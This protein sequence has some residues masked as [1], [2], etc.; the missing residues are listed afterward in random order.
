MHVVCLLTTFPC[1]AFLRTLCNFHF[2]LLL[3]S[4]NTERGANLMYFITFSKNNVFNHISDCP[5]AEFIEFSIGS[6]IVIHN[7]RF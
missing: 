5:V 3:L 1:V 7:T 6:R 2:F 4:M